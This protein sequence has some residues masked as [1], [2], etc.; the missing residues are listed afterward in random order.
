[1]DNTKVQ[2][3]PAF[4]AALHI[5]LQDEL[6][7]III[8]EEHLLGK[9]PMQMD[10]LVIKK[11]SDEILEKNIARIFRKHNV[12]EYKS[13]DDS[14]NV[15]DFYKVM[16]YAC[17]YQ[18]DTEKV[19]EINPEDITVTFVCNA[20]P[21]KMI[22][23]LKLVRNIQI[24]K[25]EKGIYYLIGGMFPMQLLI[26]KQL[27]KKM[28]YWL[29]SLRAD[30]K[31]GGE[32]RELVERY[33]KNKDSNW[34]QAVMEVIMRANWREAEVEKKMCDALRELFADELAESRAD[35]ISE[36]HM[37]GENDGIELA[38][39]VFR[40]SKEKFSISEI[41]AQCGI[42]EEKVNQILE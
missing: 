8:E 32:I 34:C 9:K 30:L 31:A 14:L 28:N 33:E 4:A 38:K 16:G 37:A 13:P 10:V 41:A 40:L 25:Q 26:T 22:E 21:R 3:H 1:M 20:Y 15:N 18:S 35:G 39:K 2:W 11:K 6:E 42:A 27:S 5:E 23:H 17:F 7:K 12:I 24:V 19:E 36:G 29:R